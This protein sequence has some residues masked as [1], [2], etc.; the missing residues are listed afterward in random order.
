MKYS[1]RCSTFMSDG[2][3]IIDVINEYK[4][5]K[6]ISSKGKSLITRDDTF[7]FE[8]WLNTLEDKNMLFND[9]KIFIDSYGGDV[10]WHE[11][12]HDEDTREPCEI[13]EIYRGV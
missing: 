7:N 6:L 1:I 10:N 2:T 12:K 3:E 13:A 9:L 4:I 8:V 5:W 11:C